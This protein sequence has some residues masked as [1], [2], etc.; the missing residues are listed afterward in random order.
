MAYTKKLSDYSFGNMMGYGPGRSRPGRGSGRAS[1]SGAPIVKDTPYGRLVMSP[2]GNAW[3]LAGDLTHGGSGSGP[4]TRGAPNEEFRLGGEKW[5]KRERE[6]M[7][8]AYNTYLEKKKKIVAEAEGKTRQKQQE[9][10][11]R[12]KFYSDIYNNIMKNAPEDELDRKSFMDLPE[13]KSAREKM[14]AALEEVYGKDKKKTPERQL[15]AADVKVAP[16]QKGETP[17]RAGQAGPPEGAGMRPGGEIKGI[18]QP[19]PSRWGGAQ[20]KAGRMYGGKLTPQQLREYPQAIEMTSGQVLR[21]V[22]GSAKGMYVDVYDEQGRRA[23]IRIDELTML[24]R[25]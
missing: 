7:D 19:G 18:G 21:V 8:K 15:T 5:T 22:P 3:S 24:P 1:G 13:V 20:D 4:H 17:L 23:K 14:M 9:K 10:M 6:A 12:A 25:S 11:Q 16:L 2:S